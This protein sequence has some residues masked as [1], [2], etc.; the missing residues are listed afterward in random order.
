[1]V[2]PFGIFTGWLIMLFLF[3]F[4]TADN[5]RTERVPS[6]NF[7]VQKPEKKAASSPPDVQLTLTL[8]EVCSPCWGGRI[9]LRV[10]KLLMK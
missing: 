5:F 8:A 7:R 1:M 4:P 2:L 9:L 3:F 10:W 6:V